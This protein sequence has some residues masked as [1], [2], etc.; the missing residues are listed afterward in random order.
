MADG[1]GKSIGSG[2]ATGAKIGSAGLNPAALGATGG[3]SALAVPLG[4]IAGGIAGGIKGKKNQR[5]DPN[6]NLPSIEDPTQ[7]S[8]MLEVDRIARNIRAGS[9]P[10]T[11]TAL[12]QNAQTTGATQSRLS[13]ITGGN[14]G[15]TVDAL[16]KAQRAGQSAGNQAIAQGQSRLPFFQNLAQQL[17]SR[18]SQRQLELELLDRA[19]KSAERAQSQKEQNV[20]RNAAIASGMPGLQDSMSRIQAMINA[21]RA[22]SGEVDPQMFNPNQNLDQTIISPENA[23]PSL[24]LESM[25]GSQGTEVAGLGGAGMNDISSLSSLSF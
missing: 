11:Q 2:A 24:G 3:L 10:A 6:Q 1:I 8:R 5:K 14:T 18:A 23:N 17:S 21:N 13:R 22:Q 19:Q 25:V 4:A 15:A 9:D 7:T 20:N 16:L 12:A